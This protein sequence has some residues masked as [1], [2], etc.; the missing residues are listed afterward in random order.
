MRFRSVLLACVCTAILAAPA[1]VGGAIAANSSS[2]LDMSVAAREAL[3]ESEAILREVKAVP[4]LARLL[5]IRAEFE[6]RSENAAN[7]QTLLAEA[8]SLAIQSGA[9]PQSELGRSLA[10]ARGMAGGRYSQ[11]S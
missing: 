10:R 5:C 4:D 3:Q 8:E 6:L 7:A 1:A 9:G 11:R 2:P